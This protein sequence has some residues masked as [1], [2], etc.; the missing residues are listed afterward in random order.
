VVE[1][2]I[3]AGANVNMKND[4]G[5]TA[6]MCASVVGHFD[7]VFML[8]MHGAELTQKDL[9]KIPPEKLPAFQAIFNVQQLFQTEGVSHDK[10]VLRFRILES[11]LRHH[12]DLFAA[13][14]VCKEIVEGLLTAYDRQKTQVKAWRF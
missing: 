13:P 2:L 4:L 9:E 3:E 14:E 7:I 12:P 6:L 11:E 10:Q 5:W 8:A 1:A